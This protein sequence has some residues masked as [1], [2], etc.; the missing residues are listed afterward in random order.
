[1]CDGQVLG[2][3]GAVAISTMAGRSNR[4]FKVQT[5]ENGKNDDMV[6]S[7]S[8]FLDYLGTRRGLGMTGHGRRR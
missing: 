7:L 2:S 1:M 4:P 3:A 8:Q 6:D 5:G